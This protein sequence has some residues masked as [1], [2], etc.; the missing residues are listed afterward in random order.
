LAPRG[1]AAHLA[2]LVLVTMRPILCD[3][4]HADARPDPQVRQPGVLFELRPEKCLAIT[5]MP[6][7]SHRGLFGTGV[8]MICIHSTIASRPA[9]FLGFRCRLSANHRIVVSTASTGA[10]RKAINRLGEDAL[11]DF[12]VSITA[13]TFR[14]QVLADSR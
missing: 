6:A 1:C 2:D 3:Q 5:F 7:K 13:N 14:H 10:V 4:G 11:G 12:S 8:T 9:V